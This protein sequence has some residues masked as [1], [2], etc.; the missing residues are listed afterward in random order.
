M[1]NIHI[2]QA[3]M[4]VVSIISLVSLVIHSKELKGKD[5]IKLAN[6]QMKKMFDVKC[7][8]FDENRSGG[9]IYW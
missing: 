9:A 7:S 3:A 1:T 4:E 8:T 2:I 6:V 5:K